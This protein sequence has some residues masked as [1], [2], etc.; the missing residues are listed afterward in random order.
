[1]AHFL[2]SE[3]EKLNR[4]GEGTYGIVYRAKDTATGEIVALK[5]LRNHDQ[6]GIALSSLREINILL[7]LRHQNIIQLKDVVVGRDISSTFLVMEYCEQD[8]AV[9]LDSMQSPFSEAQVKCIIIQMLEGLAYLHSKFIVH[10]D[11]KVSNLLL[12]DYGRLKIGDFGLA[13]Y[14][15]VP[16]QPMT[17]KVVTLWYRAP[18]L[19][20]GSKYQS[21]SIDI[22]AAGCIFDL[23]GTPNESIWPGFSQVQRYNNLNCIFPHLSSHGLKL[24]NAMF[25]YDPKKRATAKECLRHAYFEEHPLPCDPSLMPSFPQHRNLKRKDSVPNKEDQLPIKINKR[26][27]TNIKI[28][29][30]KHLSSVSSLQQITVISGMHV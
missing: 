18:E 21:T 13:R 15:G 23:L 2:R 5:K 19:L 1:E 25:M 17:P 14:Y 6:N 29:S 9:L 11:L 24:L 20:L 28:T 12:T 4:I 8:L 27:L 3:F 22:W 10:R 30:C 16:V 26:N 7:G